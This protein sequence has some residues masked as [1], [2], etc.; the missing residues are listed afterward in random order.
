M[1]LIIILIII[2]ICISILILI[3]CPIVYTKNTG[4]KY[5]N[6]NPI[7]IKIGSGTAEC[8]KEKL[9][10]ETSSD[11]QSLCKDSNIVEFDCVEM[12]RYN[13]DQINKYGNTEKVC[14][15]KKAKRNCNSK[16]GGVLTWNAFPELDKMA[17]ACSCTYPELA[18]GP[19]CNLNPDVCSEGTYNLDVTSPDPNISNPVTATC[20]CP[21]DKQ[22]IYGTKTYIPKCIPNSLGPNFNETSTQTFYFDEYAPYDLNINPGYRFQEVE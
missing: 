3:I 5:N 16:Y 15:P 9:N 18:G 13:S 7:D 1:N 12:K 8:L 17:W 21:T 20:A 2:L 14:A 4:A 10:C 22:L 11:C 19:G 6:I